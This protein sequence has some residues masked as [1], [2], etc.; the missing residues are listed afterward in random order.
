MK[1]K[2][3][4]DLTGDQLCAFGEATNDSLA[5]NA[6]VGDSGS[7]LVAETELGLTLVGVTS[8]SGL[9]CQENYGRYSEVA[10]TY[11]NMLDKERLAWVH[12]RIHPCTTRLRLFAE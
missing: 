9:V 11:T 2:R 8:T 6:C 1:C 12:S 10:S 3:N 7:G 4:R 5:R